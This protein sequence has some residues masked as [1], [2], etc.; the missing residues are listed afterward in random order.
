[1]AALDKTVEGAIPLWIIIVAVVGGVLL[2][3]ILLVI[4]CAVGFTTVTITHVPVLEVFLYRKYFHHDSVAII[5]RWRPL[6]VS[7]VL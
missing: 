4:L 7:Q 2:L 5:I 6:F 3:V 1:M